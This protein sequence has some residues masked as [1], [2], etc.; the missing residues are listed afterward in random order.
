VR[1]V[2]C[3]VDAAVARNSARVDVAQF[4]QLA[5]PAVVAGRGN[6]V[7]LDGGSLQSVK[8]AAP[9]ATRQNDAAHWLNERLMAE[10]KP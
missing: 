7:R 5:I 4:G 8:H 10:E 6:F 9:L 2:A 3:T 1:V